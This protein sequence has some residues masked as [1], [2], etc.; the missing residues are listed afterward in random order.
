MDTVSL[1]GQ[2]GILPDLDT[3]KAVT[4]F[5]TPSSVKQVRQFLGLTSY[6]RFIHSTMLDML[7]PYL[8]SQSKILHLS[9]M[10]NVMP[11]CTF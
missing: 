9:G 4:D 6:H 8:H 10:K 3:V 5:K 2:A 11:L 1:L 7:N